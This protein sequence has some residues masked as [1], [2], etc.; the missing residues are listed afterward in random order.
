MIFGIDAAL[1]IALLAL[2]PTMFTVFVF[3]FAR[4]VARRWRGPYLAEHEERKR[5]EAEL[6][7]SEKERALLEVKL[8][9]CEG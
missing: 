8:K 3:P 7:S 5:L 9:Y 4:W 2:I 1:F 6:S